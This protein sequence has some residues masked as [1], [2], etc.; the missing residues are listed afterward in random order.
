MKTQKRILIATIA[1]MIS[2]CS[3]G[4]V[5]AVQDDLKKAQD[6]VSKGNT[7]EASKLY[8]DL[9]GKYPDSKEVVQGWLMINMKRSPDSEA[10]GIKQ[11][12]ELE[13]SHPEN[14]AI[15]FF[16]TFILAESQHFDEALVNTDRLIK[17]KPEDATFWLIRGNILGYLNKN[18]DAL[19]AYEKATLYDS[20]NADA[21]Q[22]KAGLLAK[23]NKLDEAIQSY[24]RAIELAPNQPV[25][26]YNRGCVYSR[27]GDKTNALADLAKAISMNPQFKSY[28]PSD[29]DFK[30]FW[31]D[32]DFKKIISQ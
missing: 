3:Q 19:I 9:M 10:E 32:T 1:V 29:E 20:N 11:L 30:A 31:E 26:I 24:T 8:L 12:E 22:N 7:A 27:K 28:A 13:K 2:Y 21:W 15:L 6:L 14:S 23:T 18:E 5:S 16:K 25:Y 4:Q 17:M